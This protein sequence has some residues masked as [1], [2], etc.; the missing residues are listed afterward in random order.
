MEGRMRRISVFLIVLLA[1]LVPMN[2]QRQPASIVGVWKISEV[3]SPTAN[4]SPEPSLY[5]FT[6]RYYSVQNVAS[7]RKDQ[8]N[9][10]SPDADKL[11]VWAQFTAHSGTYEIKGDELTLRQVVAKN[12]AVMG[13][14]NFIT[15]DV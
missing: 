9:D 1:C 3:L 14:G 8:V 11:A 6:N 7:K 12:S 10:Q 13:S 5:I 4:Q 15:F 2:A